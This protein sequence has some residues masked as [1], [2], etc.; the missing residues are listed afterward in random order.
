MCTKI[1]RRS[2]PEFHQKQ[3]K[4]PQIFRAYAPEPCKWCEKAPIFSG[5]TRR[6]THHQI[7]PNISNM[8][9]QPCFAAWV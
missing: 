7:S 3:S 5:A 6:E 4:R 9:L 1:C 8:C 2:A